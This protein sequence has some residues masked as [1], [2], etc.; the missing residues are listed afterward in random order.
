MDLIHHWSDTNTILFEIAAG[1]WL[2]SIIEDRAAG[3]HIISHIRYDAD[4]KNSL[5]LYYSSNLFNHHVITLFAYGYSLY[6]HKLSA[7]CVFGLLFEAPVIILTYRDI[8]VCF[9]EELLHPIKHMDEKTLKGMWGVMYLLWHICRTGACLLYPV[10]LVFWRSQLVTLSIL[11]R[12]VYHFLGCAFLYVNGVLLFREIPRLIEDDYAT[13]GLVSEDAVRFLRINQ[14]QR[15][16]L[17]D[18]YDDVTPPPV[19]LKVSGVD[20]MGKRLLGPKEL[21]KHNTA[22]DLW[23]CIEGHAY[24][25]TA[26]L[27]VHPGGAAVLLQCAGTDATAQFLEAGHSQQARRKMA[28]FEVGQ[29]LGHGYDQ[30]GDVEVDDRLMG[31]LSGPYEMGKVYTTRSDPFADSFVAYTLSLIFIAAVVREMLTR[32]IYGYSSGS[33]DGGG[34]VG[35]RA[36]LWTAVE[37]SAVLLL[38]VSL[39]CILLKTLTVGTKISLKD[40]PSTW[41][42]LGTPFSY[43]SMGWALLD[44]RLHANAL[45]LLLYVA[46]QWT[47]F[48]Y[49]VKEHNHALRCIRAS[50]VVSFAAEFVYRK[51]MSPP[52]HPDLA[53]PFKDFVLDLGYSL[54]PCGLLALA[55]LLDTFTVSVHTTTALMREASRSDGTDVSSAASGESESAGDASTSV[56]HHAV[57]IMCM[58]V[59]TS[60]LRAAVHH[61]LK[62]LLSSPGMLTPNSPPLDIFSCVLGCS[63][64][65]F[66]YGCLLHFFFVPS[67]S[68]SSVL[69]SMDFNVIILWG[70]STVILAYSMLN[71]GAMI[72]WSTRHFAVQMK[73][74]GAMMILWLLAPPIGV[75]RWVVFLLIL[76]ALWF[77][78]DEGDRT[79]ELLAATGQCPKWIYAAKQ[80]ENMCRHVVALAIHTLVGQVSVAIS[81]AIAP[82]G[83]VSMAP[84]T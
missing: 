12:L 26:F 54:A 15:G 58:I 10:S 5:Y 20:S 47:V 25:V 7:L 41:T 50:L 55:A 64:I 62:S 34:G 8:C 30:S 22:D 32:K 2:F 56:L 9:A 73:S 52:R 68:A 57:T 35:M 61:Q 43:S 39:W 33:S 84:W 65:G 21:S 71:T 63:G 77:L 28:R 83:Q 60:I 66:A 1:H 38:C 46:C 19:E 69:L 81:S 70:A 6:S 45:L 72:N 29:M 42:A 79:L 11:P 49:D 17:E 59:A 13:N 76:G 82:K 75:G 16:E 31:N 78:S 27:E 4:E 36:S 3:K 24:D 37:P 48:S 18:S 51:V 53:M 67:Y 80:V 74:I 40:L 14:R 44:W 23:I